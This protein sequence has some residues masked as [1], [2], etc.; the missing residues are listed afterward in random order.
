MLIQ[1]REI[2]LEPEGIGR[3]HLVTVD[4]IKQQGREKNVQRHQKHN[5]DGE[6]IKGDNHRTIETQRRLTEAVKMACD[7]QSWHRR[8]KSTDSILQ[9]DSASE[10]NAQPESLVTENT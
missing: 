10:G 6:G 5:S 3:R 8:E 2:P 1:V 9:A 4:K 7:W